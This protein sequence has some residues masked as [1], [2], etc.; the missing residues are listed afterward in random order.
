MAI[1][2]KHLEWLIKSRAQNQGTS[3]KL[4]ELF[5]KYD[6]ECDPDRLGYDGAIVAQILTSITFSLWRAA[7]LADRNPNSGPKHAIDFLEKLVVD[8][9]INYTQDRSA[10]DWTWAYYISNAMYHIRQLEEV[11]PN[12]V[13]DDPYTKDACK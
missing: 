12:L 6:R 5:R 11:W 7:F 9:A 10:R 13:L 2:V 3:L 1:T 4:L 8:N